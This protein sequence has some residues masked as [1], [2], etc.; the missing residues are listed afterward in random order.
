LRHV[1]REYFNTR[2]LSFYLD[3]EAFDKEFM[4]WPGVKCSQRKLRM[5]YILPAEL[6]KKT[7]KEEGAG[8]SL[9]PE[10]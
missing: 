2:I 3:K 9:G 5:N 10:P 7:Y 1:S 4:S 6:L 8:Q